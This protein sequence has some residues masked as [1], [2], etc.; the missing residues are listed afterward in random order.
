M[1]GVLSGCSGEPAPT[2]PTAS[3]TGATPT[4]AANAPPP[5]HPNVLMVLLDALRADQLEA[6][7]GLTPSPHL[8]KLAR[9]GAAYPVVYATSSYTRSS[10]ASLMTSQFPGRHGTTTSRHVLPAELPFLPQLLQGG[11]YRTLA[12]LKNAQVA[13]EFGFGRGYDAVDRITD[14]PWDGSNDLHA[15]HLRGRR[16]WQRH[17][18]PFV[19]ASGDQPWFAYIHEIDPHEPYEPPNP[20]AALLSS[21]ARQIERRGPDGRPLMPFLFHR[22]ENRPKKSEEEVA[23]MRGR[24]RAE[25]SLMDAV[26]GTLRRE[27]RAAGLDR[28]TLL[29][30]LSDHGEEFMEHGG[31]AHSRTLYEESVRVPLV[32]HLPSL[33]EPGLRS[34]SVVSLVDVTPSLL[35]LLGLP[36]P[37]ALDGRSLAADLT[38]GAP[39]EAEPI[40]SR[41]QSK[42][43]TRDGLVLGRHKLVRTRRPEGEQVELFDLASDPEE[44]RDVSNAAPELTATMSD[45]LDRRGRF[46][47]SHGRRAETIEVEEIEPGIRQELEAL[48][49]IP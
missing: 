31:L 12:V 9:E 48:G 10:V 13:P 7:G 2:P 39:S 19:A 43:F 29:I 3:P 49:Y 6:Y 36:L 30:V 28:E 4:A 33:I 35:D 32:W 25:I 47:S 11:G 38:G 16:I 26:V 15:A 24:Y 22:P 5:A 37:E 46:E 8:A 21:P 23:Q 44:K 42:Q 1:I 40:F 17:L 45:T 18:Q 14:L 27:L 20:Y 41:I 34:G